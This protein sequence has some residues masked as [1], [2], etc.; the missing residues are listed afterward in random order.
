[1]AAG[2]NGKDACKFSPSRAAT[3]SSDQRAS[4]SNWGPCVD[5]F[6]PGVSIRSAYKNSDTSTTVMSGTS[7]AAPHTAGVAAL[8]L[9]ANPAATSE[10]VRDALFGLTTKG[11]VPNAQSTNNHLLFTDQ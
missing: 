7:M 11:I 3:N 8:Y 6:A 4:W 2:N 1:M 10:Q 5:W 9:E